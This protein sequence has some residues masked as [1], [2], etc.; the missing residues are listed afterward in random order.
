MTKSMSRRDALT[1]GAAAAM[2]LSIAAAG[3]DAQ[4]SSSS[5]AQQVEE[6]TK[7]LETLYQDALADGGSLI[8]YAGGDI[9]TQQDAAKDAFLAQF[10]ILAAVRVP[11]SRYE[12][13]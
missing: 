8:V 7:S 11:G 2:G 9:S 13:A 3:S 5:T 6:E 1:A 12:Q 10:P 4:A